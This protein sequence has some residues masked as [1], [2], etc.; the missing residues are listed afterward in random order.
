MSKL[1]QPSSPSRREFL[2]SLGVL[3]LVPWAISDALAKASIP[4]FPWLTGKYEEYQEDFLMALDERTKQA[5]LSAI[6]HNNPELYQHFAHR[7][8]LEWHLLR[9]GYMELAYFR[10][11]PK[12]QYQI[13]GKDLGKENIF[14]PI[15][16]TGIRESNIQWHT[17]YQ[18]HLPK[19]LRTIGPFDVI[20]AE[21]DTVVINGTYGRFDSGACQELTWNGRETGRILNI[22]HGDCIELPFGILQKSE[23]TINSI[24]FPRAEINPAT[25]IPQCSKAAR[26][27]ANS[28]GVSIAHAGSAFA[29][30]K[31]YGE[32]YPR[33]TS[34]DSIPERIRFADIFMR[35]KKNINEWHRAFGARYKKSWLIFDPHSHKEPVQL[36]GYKRKNDI[37]VIIG[38]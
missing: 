28:F 7:K 37:I 35:S 8:N 34:F 11:I 22:K 23:T 14:S 38:V 12:P 13:P 18:A 20:P 3:T 5:L 19:N 15:H 31:L 32:N 1:E 24:P 4:T 25:G 17:W 36:S 30:L 9:V 2:K 6:K 10:K 29:S 27:V 26:T 16:L 33:F 21:Q